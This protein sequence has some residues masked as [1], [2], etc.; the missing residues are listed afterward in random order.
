MHFRFMGR[1]GFIFIPKGKIPQPTGDLTSTP[2]SSQKWRT[3][4][5][6]LDLE[7]IELGPVSPWLGHF[8]STHL[9]GSESSLV[10]LRYLRVQE[11]HHAS[12]MYDNCEEEVDN[13]L[14]ENARRAGYDQTK[15][16]TGEIL[17]GCYVFS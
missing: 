5:E 7:G 14:M 16:E 17:T 13:A 2:R 12:L 8:P 9:K 15:L 10:K 4:N 1:P 3:L 6:K 11:T